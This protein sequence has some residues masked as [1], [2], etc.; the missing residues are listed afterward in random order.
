MLLE[1][2]QSM[3][4][5]ISYKLQQYIGEELLPYYSIVST[6]EHYLLT[7]TCFI[8]IDTS[9]SKVDLHNTDTP[10]SHFT[11]LYIKDTS[12]L[13]TLFKVPVGGFGIHRC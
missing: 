9:D 10:S 6:F 5:T 1:Y 11:V 12:I 3:Y 8:I 13:R 4:R 7:M 2:N